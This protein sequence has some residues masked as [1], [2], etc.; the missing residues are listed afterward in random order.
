MW[1]FALLLS[2]TLA[3][4]VMAQQPIGPSGPIS[5]M[6]IGVPI[7]GPCPSGF[8]LYNNFGFVGCQTDVGSGTVTTLSVVTANGVSGS[9]AN[10]TTTPAITITLGALTPSSV[11]IGAGAAITSSGAGG[12][13]GSNAFSSATNFSV[14]GTGLGNSGTTVSSNA[15]DT[16][17]FSPGLI[18]AIIN[19]KG[20]FTKWV[21]AST[22]DNVEVSA[23]SFTCTGNPTVTFFECGTSTT[24][25][26]PTT[27]GSATV[28]AG[29]MVVDGSVSAPA[30][31]AGDYTAWA[32]S[33]GT[34]A[35]LDIF[36]TAQVHS[37]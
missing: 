32:I 24:C 33:A 4:P 3:S 18:A 9:V 21:K 11:A 27:I 12:T 5:G 30:I 31:V 28:T 35:S 13:L 25:A 23:T 20:A 17:T 37:N 22:V 29:G 15:E 8:D 16:N 36:G 1:R 34:C 26:A 10:P 2:A 14:A 7:T 19:T 6:T